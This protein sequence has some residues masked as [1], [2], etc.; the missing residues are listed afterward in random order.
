MRK[1]IPV[2]ITCGCCLLSSALTSCSNS[3]GTDPAVDGAV[4]SSDAELDAVVPAQ[5]GTL[6][7]TPPAGFCAV[8]DYLPCGGDLI[9][10]W[11]IVEW[12]PGDPSAAASHCE[13]PYDDREACASAPNGAV[14]EMVRSGTLTFFADG[15]M[16]LDRDPMIINSTYTFDPG[17]M[18]SITPGSTPAQACLSM[19]Q[20]ERL[21][22]ELINE[23]CTC[24][25]SINEAEMNDVP[26]EP[27]E[28]TFEH[29]DASKIRTRVGDEPFI[30]ATYCIKGDQLIMD[31]H[32]H[33]DTWQY[34]VHQRSAL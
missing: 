22:C 26:L 20:N 31:V 28:A 25:A 23:L 29:V 10:R 17:C 19:D 7:S 34:W 8:E 12:C 5:D 30:E 18:N 15:K 27:I 11:Q 16:I 4:L 3:E 33:E 1:L 13:H 9:G 21:S 2:M 32:P 24:Q 6:D 14:C